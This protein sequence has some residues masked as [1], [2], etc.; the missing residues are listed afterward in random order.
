[1][2]IVGNTLNPISPCGACRQVICEL[3]EANCDIILTNIKKDVKIIKVK[4]LLPYSFSEDDL[5]E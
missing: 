1:M 3:M 5:N 4:D 2:L